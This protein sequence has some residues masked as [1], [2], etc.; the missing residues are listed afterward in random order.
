MS[1]IDTIFGFFDCR[2]FTNRST[3][4]S[5]ALPF[6]PLTFI[7]NLD[8]LADYDSELG[9]VKINPGVLSRKR[10][11]WDFGD[12]TTEE[13]VSPTHFFREPGRYKVTCY[14]YDR[15]GSSYYNMYSQTVNIYNYIPDSIVLTADNTTNI[16][17]TAGRFTSPVTVKRSTSWQYYDVLPS[18]E[19][20]DNNF[21]KIP[22][23]SSLITTQQSSNIKQQFNIDKPVNII[24]YISGAETR[25]YFERGLNTRHYNHLYP[26]SSLFLKKNSIDNLTEFVEISSFTTSSTPIYI[27]PIGSIRNRRIVRCSSEDKDSF[28]CGTT[29]SELIYYKDDF[30]SNR[31]NIMLGFEGGAIKPYSNTSTIGFKT[32]TTKNLNYSQLSISSN[33]LDSEGLLSKAKKKKI[34]YIFPIGKNKFSNSKIGIVIKVKDADNFTIKD[35]PLLRYSSSLTDIKLYNSSGTYNCT[36]V[37]DFGSLS[38][39]S[40][41]GFWKGYIIPYTNTSLLNVRLSATAVI[42][43]VT[44]QGVSN[45]FNIYPSGGVYEIAKKGEDVDFKQMFKDVS[46]QPLFQDKVILFNEFLGTIFGDIDSDQDSIGK[47]TY[48]KIKNFIDNNAI[49]DYCNIDQLIS[50]LNSFNEKLP[51]FSSTNFNTPKELK[52]LVDLLSIKQGL[53]FGSQNKF[54]KNFDK[55][56]YINSEIYGKNLGDKLPINYTIIPGQHIVAH[57]KFGNKY[58][59][60]NTY[61]PLCASSIILGA[62]NTYQ[63]SSYNNTWGWGLIFPALGDLPKQLPNYY[64]FYKYKPGIDGTNNESVINFDDSNTSLTFSSSS[65]Q[66]WS[67]EEGIIANI[68]TQKL[69]SNLN[70]FV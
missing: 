29:G 22:S 3:V 51:T 19:I 37:S 40:R 48:E 55:F 43:G 17:L 27:K 21:F 42:D 26:Y 9:V 64:N 52:R 41:G 63:L 5:Y 34:P 11:V 70:L 4:S 47:S 18:E 20:E 28:F 25:G 15:S 32:T 23:K 1:N 30:Q 66:N 10:I 69:Y 8:Q 56:G 65:Y 36:I 53:L 68:I 45:T 24:S 57:E 6:T 62:N 49:L 7:P 39:L 61:L 35:I 31:T 33:G 67:K 16:S 58:S 44:I 54:N 13:V 12:G 2:D 46:T 14:L 50:I 38:S 59:L 60:L